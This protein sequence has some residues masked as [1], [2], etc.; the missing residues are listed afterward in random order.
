[1]EKITKYEKDGHQ[2][3]VV[4]VDGDF[5]ELNDNVVQERIARK[6]NDRA[7]EEIAQELERLQQ[8]DPSRK[9]SLRIH[10]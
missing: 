7:Q 3:V 8:L 10:E 5:I 1:M 6:I 4:S 2:H 9:L